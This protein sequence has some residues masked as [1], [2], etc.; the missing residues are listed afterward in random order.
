MAWYDLNQTPES[1]TKSE[2][3]ARIKFEQINTLQVKRFQEI[4]GI[5]PEKGI[6]YRIITE[7]AF[8]A[9][10]V[11]S[12]LQERYEFEEVYMAVYRMN[13]KAVQALTKFIDA[14]N[15]D[16]HVIMSNFFKENKKYEAWAN[17]LYEYCQSK[18]NTH[19]AFISSHA[20]IFAGRTK[21]G[22]NFVFEGSGNYSDNARVEQYIFEDN[23][24]AFNFHKSW[25]TQRTRDENRK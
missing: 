12:Y 15:T 19:V 6:Q 21:C 20:K 25:I 4:I 14:N 7:N 5:E 13:E 22:R 16:F 10:T 11:I 3:T 17:Q 18:E 2:Y 8:N 1:E 9:I 23:E 24:A